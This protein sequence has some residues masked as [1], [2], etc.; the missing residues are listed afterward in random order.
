MVWIVAGPWFL[1]AAPRATFDER[2]TG[3]L[4]IQVDALLIIET[5]LSAAGTIWLVRQV[6]PGERRA[7]LAGLVVAIVLVGIIVF[8]LN[9]RI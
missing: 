6:P 5:V 9:P 3:E 7:G 1:G 8:I 4:G 2:T